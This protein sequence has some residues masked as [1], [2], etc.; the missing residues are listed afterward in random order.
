MRRVTHKSSWSRSST[1]ALV[2]VV[3]LQS[4]AFVWLGLLG[5]RN[6]VDHRSIEEV[7]Y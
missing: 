7:T 6:A 3:K 2:P 1:R 4:D 5:A